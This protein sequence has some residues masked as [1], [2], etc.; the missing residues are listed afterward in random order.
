M[1]A[2]GSDA[3]TTPVATLFTERV[4]CRYVQRILDQGQDLDAHGVLDAVVRT[5][6]YHTTAPIERQSEIDHDH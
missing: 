6:C 1:H 2:G 5:F 4:H 3:S